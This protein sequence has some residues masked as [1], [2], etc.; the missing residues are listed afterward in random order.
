MKRMH[1]YALLIA[2]LVV[3]NLVNWLGDGDD[4]PRPA[5]ASSGEPDLSLAAYA[6][7]DIKL[8][9]R[10]IFHDRKATPAPTRVAKPKPRPKPAPV[11]RKDPT[12]AQAQPTLEMVGTVL[13]EGRRQAFV[14]YHGDRVTVG[15]GDKLGATLTVQSVQA[16]TMTLVH[17]DS[18][19]IYH[20]TMTGSEQ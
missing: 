5:T 7:Q 6:E 1:V 2:L 18:G 14:I 9:R 4:R 8:D 12:P 3:L 11:V 13:R 16:E 15:A 17:K 20:Y 19:E 10:D